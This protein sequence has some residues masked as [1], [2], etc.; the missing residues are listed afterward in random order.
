MVS[1]TDYCDKFLR[2]LYISFA[3]LYSISFASAAESDWITLISGTDGLE[4]FYVDGDADWIAKD[5][6]VQATS[7]TGPSWLVSRDSYANCW[8]SLRDD[9]CRG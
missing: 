9:A 7:G 1:L 3:V 5:N 8:Q 6:S 2:G 4:N